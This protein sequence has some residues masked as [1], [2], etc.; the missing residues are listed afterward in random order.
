MGSQ[1]QQQGQKGN[2]NTTTINAIN[3]QLKGLSSVSASS[4]FRVLITSTST[5]TI[6]L[7]PLS[8]MITGH[9]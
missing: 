9:H 6:I 4:K 5:S 1:N 7:N 8:T 2:T 3:H